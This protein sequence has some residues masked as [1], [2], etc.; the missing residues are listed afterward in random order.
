MN[1][2]G[3]VTVE[4]SAF[5]SNVAALA[6][7]NGAVTIIES[8]FDSNRGLNGALWN[9]GELTIIGSTFSNN[10]ADD[11]AGGLLTIDGIPPKIESE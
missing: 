8:T 10:L 7:N 3:V 5:V 6:N 9:N 1:N 11:V 2:A 4:N